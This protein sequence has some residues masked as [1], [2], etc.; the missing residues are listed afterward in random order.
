MFFVIHLLYVRFY[1]LNCRA[2]EEIMAEDKTHW[3]RKQVEVYSTELSVYE[4]YAN[5]LQQILKTAVKKYAPFAIVESRA[6]TI[7]SFAEKALRKAHK[8]NDPVHQLTDLCGARVITQT[9]SEVKIICD[10][11]RDN[12]RVD[13]AN[14]EDK[15]QL[16]EPTQFTY[17]SVH[18]VVQL[19]AGELLGIMIPEEIGDKKA[20]IQVRTLLQHAWAG[21]SHDRLYKNDFEVPD[22]WKR[23]SNRLAAVLEEVDRDFDQFLENL[24]VYATYRGAYM[25]EKQMAAEIESLQVIFDNEKDEKQQIV[26]ALRIAAIARAAGKWQTVID[27]LKPYEKTANSAVLRELGKAFC[28]A[29]SPDPEKAGHYLNKAA[30]LDYDDAETLAAL[31]H[32]CEKQEDDKKALDYYSRAFELRPANPYYMISFLEYE[33][34][35]RGVVSIA[36]LKPMLRKAVDTCGLHAGVNIELPWAYF[37]MG[38]CHLLLNEPYAC[39][40]AYAKALQLCIVDTSGIP[41]DILNSEV[42]SLNRLEPIKKLID[43]VDWVRRLLLAGRCAR[44]HTANDCRKLKTMAFEKCQ[45]PGYFES[46]F[47][48][49]ASIIIVAGSCGNSDDKQQK[50]LQQMFKDAFEG[51]KGVVISG[52]T[53]AGIGGVIGWLSDAMRAVPGSDFVTIGYLPGSLPLHEEQDQRYDKHRITAG[54]EFSALEP[55]QMWI[56]LLASGVDPAKVKLI[57]G[58]GGNI[59]ACEYRLA[60][61]LGATVGI[62]TDRGGASSDLLKDETWN[63]SQNLCFLPFD[64]MTLRAF[65][66]IPEFKKIDLDLERAAEVVHDKY[67]EDNQNNLTHPSMLS[68]PELAEPLRESNR[69]Q[70]LFAGSILRRT[71]YGLRKMPQAKLK[72]VAFEDDEIEKMAAMEHGRWNAERIKGGWK[73]GTRDLDKKTSPYLVPWSQLP[74]KIK[75]DD[76]KAVRDWPQVFE[77]IG[78]E[79]YKLS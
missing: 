38:K 37:T 2:E 26:I 24:D 23:E 15:L 60:A 31:G 19:K 69:Q 30:E 4:S 72:M 12:F 44:K 59:T 27:Y 5:T 7:P 22:K 25:T 68:W 21:I 17:L 76:R 32:L 55:L 8:Y 64:P 56:D 16:L 51:F 40:N 34:S 28:F 67:R 11:I 49:A 61:A 58:D 74:E 41:E 10:F 18:Y 43:G 6:K 79:I 9:L 46:L 54:T 52:G 66:T 14:S 35:K 65:I 77:S 47:Q 20:E 29:D 50:H 62:L 39:L 70:V 42:R 48:E 45:D 13:E 53:T 57:G 33:I 75:E 63:N 73:P 71:G 36:L 3:H 1:N 78:I